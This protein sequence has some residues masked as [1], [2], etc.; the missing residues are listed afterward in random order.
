M[1]STED[2]YHETMDAIFSELDRMTADRDR[3]DEERLETVDELLDRA[4]HLS[5]RLDAEAPLL[6]REVG[7]DPNLLRSFLRSPE[8]QS[9]AERALVGRLRGT[10][11]AMEAAGP[12]EATDLSQEMAGLL[13]DLR[14]ELEQKRLSRRSPR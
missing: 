11:A 3:F 13:E 10:H 12:A 7:A 4:A 1:K 9:P 6:V 14:R 8:H 2:L 5:A